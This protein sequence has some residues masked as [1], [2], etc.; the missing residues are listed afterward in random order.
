MSNCT[1]KEHWC[2]TKTLSFIWAFIPISQ[3]V[4]SFGQCRDSSYCKTWQ[5]YTCMDKSP[6]S[7]HQLTADRIKAQGGRPWAEK[8]QRRVIKSVS[9]VGHWHLTWTD[10]ARLSCITS[11]HTVLARDVNK[12]ATATTKYPEANTEH[13]FLHAGKVLYSIESS[14]H[15]EIP[16]GSSEG[17]GLVCD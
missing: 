17:E 15:L 13:L 11:A 16:R 8:T 2:Q 5:N 3:G 9:R 7:K 1:G 10:T 4:M 14:W 6:V 12:K